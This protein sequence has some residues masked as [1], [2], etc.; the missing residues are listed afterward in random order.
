MVQSHAMAFGANEIELCS[1]ISSTLSIS[2]YTEKL[3]SYLTTRSGAV[4][5]WLAAKSAKAVLGKSKTISGIDGAA[6]ELKDLCDIAATGDDL[7]RNTKIL[8]KIA[9]KTGPIGSYIEAQMGAGL[10]ALQEGSRLISD[11]NTLGQA[12]R[13]Q[14]VFNIR[15]YAPRW[16]WSDKMLDRAE[17][18][19]TVR[20][21]QVY[22]KSNGEAQS[23][24][25]ALSD[26]DDC[27][28]K[29]AACYV[30]NFD[31]GDTAASAY[32]IRIEL[33]NGQVVYASTSQL[34]TI[35]GEP[36]KTLGITASL[37]KGGATLFAPR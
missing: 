11:E 14:V 1:D 35:S 31:Y 17:T 12:S 34:Q 25:G 5:A 32:A 9:G 28:G 15:L 18:L 30:A 26:K 29:K 13:S 22:S 16:Y 23:A 36:V 8:A 7:V 24:Q 21:V 2:T 27:T 10:I 20:S 19:N 37:G 3:N 6:T 33:N 4:P